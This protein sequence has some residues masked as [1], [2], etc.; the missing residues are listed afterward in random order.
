M[1]N[2]IASLIIV[3]IGVGLAVWFIRRLDWQVVGEH[4]RGIRVW[5]VVLA[6]LLINFTLLLRSL[7]WRTLLAPI[8]RVGL[9][10]LFSA[11]T[12]GFGSVFVFGRAGE[13]V[14]PMVLSLKER[15]HPSATVATILVE[16]VFD[17]A[18]VATFFAVNLLFFRLPHGQGVETGTLDTIHSVGLLLTVATVAGIAVLIL[19]RV[20]TAWIVEKLEART[21]RFPQRLV[22]PIIGFI[23]HLS[24]G[25][26]VLL[27]LRELLICVFYTVLVWS[28]VTGATWL[29][30]IAF[31]LDLGL[32]SAVFV[33]GF[34][35]LGSLVPSPG[36]SAGAFHA[37]A[38][39]GLIFLGIE[40]NLA[41]SAAIV[42]HFV[43]F[44]PPFVLGMF[45]LVKD[46]IRLGSL[47]EMIASSKTE[48][49][50]SSSSVS[51]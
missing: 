5:P 30:L 27:N 2:R 39:A 48:D 51:D 44:G 8:A 16:R 7:R 23:S 49:S 43:A 21:K 25:L 26:S 40:R 41:A 31:R 34:G 17:M 1:R 36:G 47:R 32:T 38:A 14:R 42:F 11:T 12:I 45:Y 19:F 29:V 46:G 22:R 24:S 35:L 18:A 10:S 50:E 9:G 6:A 28:C 3:A 15:L 37:A 13:I 33:M 20:R 4:L